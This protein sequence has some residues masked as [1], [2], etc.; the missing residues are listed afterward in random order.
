MVAVKP[1]ALT[2]K[3]RQCRVAKLSVVRRLACGPTVDP[4]VYKGSR[5]K[6]AP[7]DTWVACAALV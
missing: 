4:T 2:R 5:C 7:M 6:P 3:L 1:R